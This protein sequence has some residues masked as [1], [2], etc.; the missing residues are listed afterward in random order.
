MQ[1]FFIS[2]SDL[3][4]VKQTLI[5]YENTRNSSNSS[6]GYDCPILLVS[7]DDK[8]QLCIY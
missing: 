6:I 5:F 2:G 1:D 7:K 8:R 3:L 4:Q